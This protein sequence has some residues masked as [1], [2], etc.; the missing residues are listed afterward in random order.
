MNI[1]LMKNIDELFG[2]PIC[3]VFHIYNGIKKLFITPKVTPIGKILLLKFFG[4]GSIIMM[5]P[6][7]RALKSKYPQAKISILTFSSNKEICELFGSFEK[8]YTIGTGSIYGI[9]AETF[10]TISYLRKQKFDVCIDLE[11]FTKFS[12]I[13]CYLSGANI[14][15]GYFLIQVGILLKMMWR[16]NLLTHQVY[17][18]QHKHITEAFLALARAIGAD[19]DDMSC[20]KLPVPEEASRS[21]DRLLSAFVKDYE[22]LIVVNINSGALCLERRWP[23]ENFKQLV[24]RLL[25]DTKKPRLVFIG[26][27]DDLP[28]VKSFLEL[29]PGETGRDRI[30][31]LTGMLSVSELAAL[32]MRARL[33]ITNDSGPLHIA[34]S[35]DT[36]TVSFFGPETPQRFGPKGDK[37]LILYNE[38]IYCSPCLNVYNQ[39]TAFCAGNNVCI[40][41]ITP[42]DT[43]CRMREKYGALFQ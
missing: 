39:K 36:P 1:E 23:K 14:R 33:L 7:T 22:Y 13:V 40:T 18:N 10:K 32:L 31:D 27:Q 34:A 4:I 3:L 29:F 11:F 19:T 25:S 43:Y 28:Y 8:I 38:D 35:L 26:A 15:V 21:V 9:I 24:E 17:F 20:S 37:H 5:G 42:Q 6:M 2:P 30:I 12:T 41:S 16:G